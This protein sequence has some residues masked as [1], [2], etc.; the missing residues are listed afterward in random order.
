MKNSGALGYILFVI[1]F[2]AVSGVFIFISVGVPRM[3]STSSALNKI[4][5]YPMI[6][7]DA[8]HGGEDGGA[9]GKNGLYEKDINLKIAFIMKDMLSSRGYDVLLTRSEDILLYDRNVDFKGRKKALDLA[10][11]VKIAQ[12]YDD[13]IF[14]SIHMNAFPDP[15][16]SG[17]QVYYSVNNENSKILA[18]EI[19]TLIKETLQKENNRKTKAAGENIFVLDRIISP[20]ILIECGFLSNPEE[21]AA[22]SDAQYLKKLSLIICEAVE[23]YIENTLEMK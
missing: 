8:G 7:I 21:C 3:D 15:K 2:A 11:R 13:C 16:Y 6:I 17:L 4:S 19:Q 20:A 9:V 22:L 5:E 1:L 10:A 23:K 18:D 12:E 14:I